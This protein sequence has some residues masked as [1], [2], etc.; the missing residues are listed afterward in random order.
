MMRTTAT[1]AMPTKFLIG[2]VRNARASVAA[3]KQI[4]GDLL[5]VPPPC[6]PCNSLLPPRRCRLCCRQ[7]AARSAAF[8]T[9]R[10]LGAV[11]C[12]ALPPTTRGA[13]P[14][15]ETQQKEMQAQ[16]KQSAGPHHN[17]QLACWRAAS[18]KHARPP[19]STLTTVCVHPPRTHVVHF[20]HVSPPK[21]QSHKVDHSIATP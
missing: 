19:V 16:Q 15:T 17:T 13:L 21:T 18:H 2:Q 9:P 5:R 7:R 8:E 12:G 11:T 4:T 14:P 10:R 3:D 6:V 1:L 20:R